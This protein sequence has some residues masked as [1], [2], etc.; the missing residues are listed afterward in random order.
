AGTYTVSYSF[1]GDNTYGSSSAS[2][3]VKIVANT[4]TPT[5]TVKSTTTFGRGANT[6]F[7]VALTVDGVPLAGKTVTITVNGKPYAK[8]TDSNGIASLPIGLAV[9]VYKISYTNTADSEISSASGST[10]ITV[11]ERAAT[12]ITWGS[13]TSFDEG[14]QT[15]KVLLKDS[16]NKALSGK[17]VQL[18]INSKTYSAKTSSSGYAT[19][20][21]DVPAGSYTVSFSYPATGDNEN[22]PS[23]GS[24]KISVVKKTTEKTI[25][26]GY[27]YWLFGGDMKN[28]DLSSLASK[29]TTDI[30]LNYYAITAHGQSAVESWIASANKLGIRVHIWMQTFYLSGW[31][32]PVKNGAENT[33]LFN[34]KITEAKKYAAIKGVA[35]V[36]LD[37]LRYPGTAYKT[38]GGTEAINSFVKQVTEAIH[39]VNP[40][41]IVSC[42]LMPE[43]TSNIYYYGQD[44]SVISKYMDVVVPMIYKGNYKSSSSWITSTTKWFVDNSQG[45]KIW[46]GLQGYASDDNVVKLSSSEIK[47]DAQAAIDGN[48]AGVI[49]FRWGVT[50]FVDF[51]SLSGSSSSTPT[52]GGGISISDIATAA[53]NL[54]NTIASKG[55]VPTSVSVAESS[56][57]TS[58]FLYMMTKAVEYI[59]SGK[60][61]TKISPVK[62]DVPSNP[63]STAKDGDLSL[64][65]YLDLASRVSSFI[66]NYGQAPNYANSDLGHIQYSSLVDAFSRVLAYYKTNSKLPASV[67]VYAKVSASNVISTSPSE[68]TTAKTISINDIVSGATTLK[69][70]YANNNK[71]PS[72]VTAGGVKFTV[73]EFLYLMSQAI[74]QLGNSNTKDIE[75]ITGVSAASSPSGDAINA[76]LNRND[77]LTVAKTVANEIKTNKKAPNYA[78]TSLGKINYNALVDAFARVVAFYGSNDNYLPNYVTIRAQAISASSQESTPSPQSGSS[79][80]STTAKTVSISDIVSGATTLK[81]YYSS[82][83]KF[84]STVTAGGVK[85]TVPEFLYLMSQAIYQLGNSNTNDIEYITGVSAASSP[86]GDIIN[87]NLY[88]DDYLNVSYNVAN[89]IKS[90]KIAPNY[91][92]SSLGNINYTELVDAFARVV[93]FYGSNDNYLPNYVA[94]KTPGSS[95]SS[96]GATG[97]GLNE[98]CTI[99]DLTPY[100]KS[101]T[102]CPV[103]NSVIKAV[104]DSLISGLTSDYDKAQ[105]IFNYVRDTISYSFYYDTR[106]GAVGTLNAKTGNCVDH[107]HLLIAMYRTAGL[108]ARY[109][110]G[111]CTFS[112]G[113]TYGHVWT[114]VLIDGNWIVGDATSSRNS[115]GNIVNWNTNYYSLNGMYSGISF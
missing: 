108:A 27:G 75:Y 82:N 98:K 58:Q 68:E 86:S 66:V 16:N 93:A 106:Y 30:F 105:V 20:N 97:S 29:G 100:Y 70:Y 10:T 72:T 85:F 24:K 99:T 102:N 95:S 12:K 69:N 78:S 15:F 1:A 41:I 34:E 81:N 109:V 46:A 71:L 74:Y 107:S 76:N 61:S 57:S 63:S 26:D 91:A 17:T 18:T 59:N 31:E 65:A 84:P 38:S 73:P 42:A 7:Q 115:F 40:N 103:N 21:V 8:T 53:N 113:S 56:Y 43:T 25:E 11:K 55:S 80:P 52:T 92:S 32:N 13:E 64:S 50:N 4:K 2:S 49:I 22:A 89:Y 5:L 33:Q 35:G 36:H 62:S 47:K 51:N 110:H 60:T 112:S 19:F 3:K 90:N 96:I 28:A 114:Q 67:T 37:Y 104:V 23:S 44:F 48:G 6:P 101:S 83:N 88:K 39:S 14:S 9:G 45:A 94:I 77:Y 79:S 54:K 87:S 111:T